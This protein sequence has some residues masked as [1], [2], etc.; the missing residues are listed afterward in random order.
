MTGFEAFRQLPTSAKLNL[1]AL[2]LIAGALVAHL[3]PEWTHDPDLSH[4]MLMPVVCVFLLCASRGPR[5]GSGPGDA[6]LFLLAAAL[7]TAGLAGLWVAGLLAVTI[8]WASPA[9]DFALA[10]SFALLGAG[11]VAAFSDR[12]TALVPFNWTSLSAALLWALCAPLPPG[13]Y[14]RLTLGLQLRVSESVVRTLDMLGIAAHRQGNIIDLAHGSVGIEEACSGVRSL[15]S[16]VF[17]GILFSAALT[18]RP[19]ARALVIALSVPLALA[20]NF[21][22]SLVLTLLVNRGVRIEGAW[23][24]ATGYGILVVTAAL[25]AVLAIALDRAGPVT[26]TTTPGPAA[27]PAGRSAAQSALS[28]VLALAAATLVF[29]GA[30]TARPPASAGAVPD[31]E[32]MLPASAPGWGIE[33]S[34]DLYRFAG[35]LRTD[36]LAQRTYFRRRAGHVD[37]VTLYLAFWP[38]G[39]ASVGAVSAH[40]PDAC[41]PG[42]GWVPQDVPDARVALHVGAVFLPRAEHRLFVDEGYPQQVWFWQVFDGHLVDIE[43]TRSVPSLIG[44]ALKY[45]FRKGGRQAFIRVSSNR[46]WEEISGEPFVADFFNSVRALGLY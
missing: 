30:N 25:L 21:L 27:A 15:I 19:A 8:T 44:I 20:M 23:H 16:C 31:L 37:Q 33:T 41:W 9:V 38:E 2:A 13:T 35:V 18:R 39:Q 46:P 40:T 42:S 14:T 1:A 26:A 7:G 10:G 32:G 6:T 22:R 43:S 36:H 34:R 5:S 12:R 28:V 17:A 4:G 29:F 24:D 3:W 11:A 45:G